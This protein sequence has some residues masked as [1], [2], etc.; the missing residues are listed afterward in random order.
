MG[1]GRSFTNYNKFN[2]PQGTSPFGFN[3]LGLKTSPQTPKEA[4]NMM[5]AI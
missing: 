5:F 4:A 1:K 2:R 3:V